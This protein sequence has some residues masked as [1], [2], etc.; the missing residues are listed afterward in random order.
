M[1]DAASSDDESLRIVEQQRIFRA[2]LSYI[3]AG[4]ERVE[5]VSMSLHQAV[6]AAIYGVL[7]FV[8]VALAA[9]ILV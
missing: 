1:R 8:I 4:N 5:G 2:G 3:R 6:G 7:I 9:Y